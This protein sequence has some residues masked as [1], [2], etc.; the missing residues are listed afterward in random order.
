MLS[1]EWLMATGVSFI[2]N[3]FSFRV[4]KV[5]MFTMIS[6]QL[7]IFNSIVLLVSNSTHRIFYSFVMDYFFWFKIT[8]KVF[9]HNKTRTKNI[10]SFNAIWV[11]RF[12]NKNIS[13]TTY[14]FSTFP[15]I[16]QF[17]QIGFPYFFFLGL[18]HFISFMKIA[19]HFSILRILPFFNLRSSNIFSC[20]FR[21]DS[22]CSS[23]LSYIYTCWHNIL[24]IKRA[25]FRRLI[26]TR[27][28]VLVLLIAQIRQKIR[29]SI[30]NI[31]I[32]QMKGLSICI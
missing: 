2:G 24:Q 6:K 19:H 29:I 7:K 4:M 3:W 30:N 13:L 1:P 23:F 9:F 22:F 31:S 25:I 26:E 21:K 15:K 28:N 14:N 18:R 16:T 27:L 10:S 17:A 8:P 5:H 11:L 20:L 12:I 32:P